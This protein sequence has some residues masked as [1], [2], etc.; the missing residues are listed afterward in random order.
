LPLAAAPPRIEIPGYPLIKVY[1]ST[2]EQTRYSP[3]T[4]I[5]AEK[6][7]IFGYCDEDRIVTSLLKDS[8]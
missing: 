2:Q 1:G 3:A 4:I 5:S 7:P 6:L 8:I